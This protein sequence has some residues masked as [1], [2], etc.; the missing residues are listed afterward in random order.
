MMRLLAW[1]CGTL[2]GLGLGISG[3]INPAK[4]RN[5]LDLAGSWD[6]TLALVMGGALAV[7]L[8]AF[9]LARRRARPVIEASF[10]LPERR[11][12]DARL[13]SGAAI[14]GIGWGLAGLCPG[15]AIAALASFQW[16]V[17]AFVAAMLAGQWLA[18]RL[19]AAGNR[20]RAA[21]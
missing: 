21:P 18:D 19:T 8:P 16:Q 17:L 13:V 4:V 6:P 7:A 20:T 10:H 11:D 14:F 5:F 2:F 9:A 1:L 15:P 12:I 3:M